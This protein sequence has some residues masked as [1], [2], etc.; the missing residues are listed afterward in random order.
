MARQGYD[1]VASLRRCGGVDQVEALSRSGLARFLDHSLTC[2]FRDK[3]WPVLSAETRSLVDGARRKIGVTDFNFATILRGCG[4][5]GDLRMLDGNGLL[6]LLILFER[7]GLVVEEFNRLR[8]A[9]T[10][11]QL[12]LIHV[13]RKQIDLPEDRYSAV[14]QTYGGVNTSADL[15]RRGF[16]LVMAFMEAAGFEKLG[17]ARSSDLAL[18]NRPGMA[19]ADQLALIRNLWREWSG[20]D[21]E[22][23]LNAWLERYHRTSALRFLTAGAAGKVIAALK[24]M[25]ARRAEMVEGGAA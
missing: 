5:V 7:H 21:D 18:G 13:A 4:G 11:A 23:A 17:Q 20:A 22:K 1:D 10:P 16:D 15:D 8:R 12:R 6:D 14:L 19:S 9:V 3:A 25:K 24:A 2:G